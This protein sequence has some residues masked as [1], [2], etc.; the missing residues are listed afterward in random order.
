MYPNGRTIDYNYGDTGGVLMG[1][2][3]AMLDNA[4]GRLD[5][6]VDG[7]NSGDAG[8]VLEQYSYLGLST[9]VARNHPQTGINLTLVGANGSIGSGGDQYVGLDQFGRVVNQNWVNTTGTTNTT[10][11]G[12]TYSYDANSN[13]ISK[14]NVLD[15]AYSETYT[16][17][18]LNRLTSVTRGGA[19]YQSWN[20]DTQGNWSSFTSNG[21]TQTRTANAQNQITGI[22]GTTTTPVYDSNGNMVTDQSGDTLIYDAWNRLMEVKNASG[23]VIAQYTYNAQSYAVTATYPQ[24]TSQLPAGTTNY[25]Y[26]TSSWQLIE[27]RIGGTAAANVTVQMVWS[28][29]YI[30]APVLQDVYNNGVMQTGSRLYFVQDA[31]WNTTAVIGYDPASGTWNVIQRYVY[32]PYGNM[33]I[34]NPNFS[35]APAGTLPYVNN[36]YQGMSQDPV[37]GLYYERARWYSTSLGTWIS[38]DPAGYI[39][40]ADTY[41]FVMSN[42]AGAVDPSGLWNWAWWGDF[43]TSLPAAYWQTAANGSQISSVAGY[44]DGLTNAMSP[45]GGTQI[46]PLYGQTGAYQGGQDVGSS[47]GAVE[48]GILLADGSLGAVENLPN[49]LRLLDTGNGLVLATDGRALAA[50]AARAAEGILGGG[51]LLSMAQNSGGGGCD[52]GQRGEPQGPEKKPTS[53]NQMQQ[54]IDRGQA[55]QGVDRVDRPHVP[56]QQPHVHYNDGTSSNMDGS[57]H[58]AGKGAP[59]PSQAIRQWLIDNGWTP[60]PR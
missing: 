24:G 28:A 35:T 48:N 44:V 36:L 43:I 21:T 37:T 33:V 3:N 57:T 55:P 29:A 8:T 10:V 58:D 6:I 46:G 18:S 45:I 51:N 39:N 31:N 9:I 17:D 12:Y 20:L 22:S 19:S 15:S 16:Y 38:Q 54:Q 56:G 30:N 4:I 27:V 13:V 5:G 14:N 52:G 60:P 42:P 53:R 34:L 47:T 7:A 2:S 59:N 41:Q 49:V 1:N 11:D 32:S 25:L 50:A 26:Y 23:Q 40:G